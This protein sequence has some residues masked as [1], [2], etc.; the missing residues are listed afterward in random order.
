[1]MKTY[2][3]KSD[4]LDEMDNALSSLYNTGFDCYYFA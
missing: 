2:A 3:H 4:N 1:M